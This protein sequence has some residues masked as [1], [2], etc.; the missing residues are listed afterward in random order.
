MD[1]DTNSTTDNLSSQL[2]E[3]PKLQANVLGAFV[4]G[5]VLANFNKNLVLGLVIGTLAGAYAEQS[6]PGQFPNVRQFWYDLKQRWKDGR[7]H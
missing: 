6:L 4:A 2:P 1:E 5:V 7:N 3:R